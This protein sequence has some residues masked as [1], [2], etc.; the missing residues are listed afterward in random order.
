MSK[1]YIRDFSGRVL[2]SVETDAK[3][4]KVTRDFSGMIL[5]KYDARHNV[6]R[7]FSGRVIAKGD[8]SS[9]LRKD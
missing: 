2:G 4:N 7:T 3:G 5:N 8:I 9:S 1:E 6:T